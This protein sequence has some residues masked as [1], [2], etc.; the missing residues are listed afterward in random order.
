M[1][2]L[3]DTELRDLLEA[4]H[5]VVALHQHEQHVRVRRPRLDEVGGEVGDAERGK[6][7]A[8]HRAAEL[9]QVRFAALI[10]GVAERIIR[11]DEVPFFPVGAEQQGAD[12]VRFHARRVADAEHVPLAVDPGDAV[13]VAAGHDV[14]DALFVRHLRHGLGQCR[15]HVADQEVDIVALDQLARLLHRRAGVAAG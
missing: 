13:G 1:D 6:L 12:G 10:E 8:G 4:V 2:L 14:Q 5:H 15:V 7:V 11:G 9:L 3:V